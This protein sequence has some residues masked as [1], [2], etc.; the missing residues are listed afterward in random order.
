MSTVASSGSAKMKTWHQQRRLISFSFKETNVSRSFVFSWH[1]KF[2]D[3]LEDVSDR[4][5]TGRPR[6]S[7]S[8]VTKICDA[9]IEDRRRS[10][11]EISDLTEI[12]VYGFLLQKMLRKCEV[13]YSLKLVLTPYESHWPYQGGNWTFLREII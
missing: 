7:D 10:V 1:T 8:D 6:R 9:I 3:G 11:R 2:R 5:R 12:C 13:C 4:P